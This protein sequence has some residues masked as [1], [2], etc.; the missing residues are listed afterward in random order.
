[1][2]FNMFRVGQKVVCINNSP[3]SNR[4]IPEGFT[5]PRKNST[6]TIREIYEVSNVVGVL[7]EEIVNPINPRTGNE[8]GY[9][10]ERFRSLVDDDVM[11]DLLSQIV[12]ETIDK[13]LVREIE[14]EILYLV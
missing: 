3:E 2:I 4:K 8:M 10:I 1:M 12:E 14:E 5:F 6:Y 7:L 13:S 9:A 11:Q